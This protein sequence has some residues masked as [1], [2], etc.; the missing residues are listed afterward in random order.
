MV[1]DDANGRAVCIISLRHH[2]LLYPPFFCSLPSLSSSILLFTSQLLEE[3][4]PFA[5][6]SSLLNLR[7]HH[8]RTTECEQFSGGSKKYQQRRRRQRS[9]KPISSTTPS[10]SSPA[11]SGLLC[12]AA[13][14]GTVPP[15]PSVSRARLSTSLE[16]TGLAGTSWNSIRWARPTGGTGYRTSR[17]ANAFE[18]SG[19][20]TCSSS[21]ASTCSAVPPP[22]AQSPFGGYAKLRSSDRAASTSRPHNDGTV[23]R[24]NSRYGTSLLNNGSPTTSS[25]RAVSHSVSSSSGG[26]FKSSRQ[27]TAAATAAAEPLRRTIVAYRPISYSG[28]GISQP[29]ATLMDI[30]QN[31]RPVKRHTVTDHSTTPSS[32]TSSSASTLLSN[33]RA[34]FASTSAMAPAVLSNVSPTSTNKCVTSPSMSRSSSSV[35]SPV[36]T[37]TPRPIP[38]S[39]RPWR[40]KLADAQRMRD[41]QEGRSAHRLPTEPYDS[42]MRLL[43]AAKSTRRTSVEQQQLEAEQKLAQQIAALKCYVSEPGALDKSATVAKFR[44]RMA[45]GQAPASLRSISSPTGG[46]GTSAVA[47]SSSS[48]SSDPSAAV[49]SSSGSTTALSSS[50]AASASLLLARMPSLNRRATTAV[51]HDLLPSMEKQ[52]AAVGRKKERPMSLVETALG[53]GGSRRLSVVKE[54]SVSGDT[55]RPG[56]TDEQT[57]SPPPAEAPRLPADAADGQLVNGNGKT[58]TALKSA[59]ESPKLAKKRKTTTTTGVADLTTKQLATQTASQ[60]QQQRPTSASSSATTQNN[61]GTVAKRKASPKTS[62]GVDGVTKEARPETTTTAPPKKQQ[63]TLVKRLL[64]NNNGTSNNNKTTPPTTPTQPSKPPKKVPQAKAEA[65]EDGN[66]NA[67]VQFRPQS[68]LQRKLCGVAKKSCASLS[69]L[70]ETSIDDGPRPVPGTWQR[71]M[72][73]RCISHNKHLI[74]RAASESTLHVHRAVPVLRVSSTRMLTPGRVANKCEGAF[75]NRLCQT[76]NAAI[77]VRGAK[78]QSP[79]AT[80]LKMIK[81]IARPRQQRVC[82]VAVLDKALSNKR[83]LRLGIQKTLVQKSAPKKMCVQLRCKSAKLATTAVRLNIVWKE[84]KKQVAVTILLADVPEVNWCRV[85]SGLIWE[86]NQQQQ[87]QKSM[88]PLKRLQQLALAVDTAVAAKPKIVAA[89]KQQQQSNKRI[90][91]GS[92]AAVTVAAPTSAASSASAQKPGTRATAKQQQQSARAQPATTQPAQ[93][94]QATFDDG[95]QQQ[96]LILPDQS[97]LEQY[98]QHKRDALE[99]LR[100]AAEGTGAGGD[101]QKQ[102]VAHGPATPA[103]ALFVPTV[104][105]LLLSASLPGSKRNSQMLATATAPSGAELPQSLTSSF[106]SAIEATAADLRAAAAKNVQPRLRRAAVRQQQQMPVLSTQAFEK[107][108]SLFE[109]QMQRQAIELR[110]RAVRQSLHEP[111][112][113]APPLATDSSAAQQQQGQAVPAPQRRRSGTTTGAAT[114]HAV[115]AQPFVAQAQKPHQQEQRYAAHIP[116][117][118]RQSTTSVESGNSGA[119]LDTATRRLD[120][121]IDQAR[122]RH[123]QHRNKFKEAIDYLDHIFE[124]FQREAADSRP[125]KKAEAQQKAQQQQQQKQEPQAVQQQ[126]RQPQQQQQDATGSIEPVQATFRQG[127]VK[128]AK[129]AFEK[130]AAAIASEKTSNSRLRKQPSAPSSSQRPAKVALRSVL[131]SSY[132]TTALASSGATNAAGAVVEMADVDVA[133]TI[134]LPTKNSADRLDFT[135]HWLQGGEVSVWAQD[136]PHR[137]DDALLG[138]HGTEAFAAGYE[139]DEHSLG[140]CSAEVAAINAADEQRRRRQHH[141]QPQQQQSKKKAAAAPA[142]PS[143]QQKQATSAVASVPSAVTAPQRHKQQQ[144]QQQQSSVAEPSLPQIIATVIAVPSSA[145]SRPQPFRPQPQ[146]GVLPPALAAAAAA[147]STSGEQMLHKVPSIEQLRLM[148]SSQERAGSQDYQSMGSSVHSH[149]GFRP[150]ASCLSTHSLQR[151][152]LNG[153][154]FHSY[155]PTTSQHQQQQSGQYQQQ[156]Q[157]LKGSIQSL[158]DSALSTGRPTVSAYSQPF[159]LQPNRQF[160]TLARMDSQHH[161]HPQQQHQLSSTNFRPSVQQQQ[162]Q[163]LQPVQ[164]HQRVPPTAAATTT[165]TA[166]LNDHVMAI[167]ALVAELELNTTDTA[168]A[169]AEKRRSFPTMQTEVSARTK[170]KLVGT[171]QQ[172]QQQQQFLNM[173]NRS[174]AHHQL[175]G[176][177]NTTNSS[178][179]CKPLQKLNELMSL[180][181]TK[182]RRKQPPPAAQPVHGMPSSSSSSAATTTTT[183]TTTTASGNRAFETINQEKL[184]PSKVDAMARMFNKHSTNVTAATTSTAAPKTFTSGGGCAQQQQSWTTRR[185]ATIGGRAAVPSSSSFARD[186]QQQQQPQLACAASHMTTGSSRSS[187]QQLHQNGAGGDMPLLTN[188]HSSSTAAQHAPLKKQHTLPAT[189]ASSTAS[190]TM[191]PLSSSSRVYR[192]AGSRG[193]GGGTAAATTRLDDM[194]RTEPAATAMVDQQRRDTPTVV[195]EEGDGGLDEGGGGNN[196]YDNVQ[197]IRSRRR[198]SPGYSNSNNDSISL[199]SQQDAALPPPSAGSKGSAGGGGGGGGAGGRIGQLIRKLGNSV[200]N[201][202]VP[203]SAASMLSLNRVS[204]D[205]SGGVAEKGGGMTATTAVGGGSDGTLTKSTSLSGERWRYQVLAQQPQQNGHKT[206]GGQS[207]NKQQQ[208]QNGIGNRLKQT[209]FGSAIRR[210]A[211]LLEL[212]ERRDALPKQPELPDYVFEIQRIV[213]S[214]F[215]AADREHFPPQAQ[216]AV[217]CSRLD[218]DCWARY[219]MPDGRHPPPPGTNFTSM[220]KLWNRTILV[221]GQNSLPPACMQRCI[222]WFTACTPP[223]TACACV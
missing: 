3:L 139:S 215:D 73:D 204:N 201:G 38:K 82:S 72:K 78:G 120:Q 213:L 144:H 205:P 52:Q 31:L 54:G 133:E 142:V 74:R 111:N 184:N 68:M 169:A 146:L 155:T 113:A 179:C 150:A 103:T 131:P 128:S 178:S 49:P 61:D 164:Q 148:R 71:S 185:A 196:F 24:A 162:Q 124:D 161:H 19:T 56:S 95:V 88:S 79:T 202:K 147:A 40:Q 18:T 208:Q 89:Q 81:S 90:P 35:T 110:Q 149:D 108:K 92:T 99:Q 193:G 197:N 67:V 69:A 151:I 211:R 26:A 157:Q 177:S 154:A 195:D 4:L 214:L 105:V 166:T 1:L 222:V 223:I 64:T 87:Q 2:L 192:S 121:M 7:E 53:N 141:P 136:A 70:A 77:S 188:G 122:Y 190:C 160:A 143:H 153:G 203:T 130:V 23:I 29:R 9:I 165:A 199:C 93:T 28:G 66:Y 163:Q 127:S 97:L 109:E 173:T 12:P 221:H 76:H 94:L 212:F 30:R 21:A 13:A 194:R 39:E 102:R 181:E 60:Q 20:S 152:G 174:A 180:D 50:A 206:D 182:Q 62:G 118:G 11:A 114:E 47:A 134:V 45:E 37:L 46:G 175:E 159:T 198:T 116:L 119:Q 101:R 34:A 172:Q 14:G 42:T 27:T 186:Q 115:V 100:A 33:V 98:V 219:L 25:A 183:T 43:A 44:Q 32:R 140:S 8:G 6:S 171:G 10:S 51:T 75:V 191:A 132:S 16:P 187:Y 125:A 156:Q 170:A 117:S 220:W 200:G 106:H 48:S 36:T 189:A 176:S 65:E 168:T 123:N 55:P 96:Q 218:D 83:R 91:L 129:E 217:F 145:T 63:L 84:Q 86:Q 167:D 216:R 104:P 80:V 107:P 126:Q 57:L 112:A 41:A 207:N 17:L 22:R 58:P 59:K 209:I 135:K 85:A 5:A 137:R 138:T 158:P 15:P 210:R